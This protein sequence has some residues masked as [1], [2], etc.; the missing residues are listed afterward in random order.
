M[1]RDDK[2]R[3]ALLA[4]Y[5]EVDGLQRSIETVMGRGRD[6]LAEV[7]WDIRAFDMALSYAVTR[8]RKNAIERALEQDPEGQHALLARFRAHPDAL[9]A[10]RR[11]ITYNALLQPIIAQWVRELASIRSTLGEP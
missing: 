2:I 11:A 1:L 8:N 3:D 7:G 5:A 9:R 6:P 10:T 4:Y